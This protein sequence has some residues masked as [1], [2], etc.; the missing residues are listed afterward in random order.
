MSNQT[1]TPSIQNIFSIRAER[2]QIDSETTKEPK[3]K[4]TMVKSYK[5]NEERCIYADIPLAGKTD[6]D[7]VLEA[8][9]KGT[10]YASLDFI[11]GNTLQIQTNCTQHSDVS[12]PIYAQ[13][14]KSIRNQKEATIGGSFSIPFDK[15]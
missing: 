6:N 3:D 2:V 15:I 7:D 5:H 10:T 13:P 12:G 11:K 1:P 14:F 8:G 9:Q 4:N